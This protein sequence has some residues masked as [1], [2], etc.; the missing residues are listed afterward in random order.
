VFRDVVVAVDGTRAGNEA[1]R[2]AAALVAPG[3]RV[4]LIGVADAYSATINEWAG[5]QLLSADEAA[6]DDSTELMRT[7]LLRGVR[8]SLEALHSQLDPGL[9]VEADVIEGRVRDVLRDVASHADLLALGDHGRS[10]MAGILAAGTVTEL[11]HRS[12]CSV[13]ISRP[14]FDP[15]RFPVRIAVAVDGSEPSLQ[16]LDVGVEIAG[17]RGSRVDSMVAGRGAARAADVARA[18]ADVPVCVLSGSVVGA[19]AEVGDRVDLMLLGAQ[20]HTGTRALG[21][22][23]ERVAHKSSASVLVVRP[24]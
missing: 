6:R 16:A 20:G 23:A 5:E 2:Q 9:H 4:R 21:S 15:A 3:G 24:S 12:D 14:C 1:G 10:R 17:A 19:L 8:G 11:L 18:R 13:L 22:V 7:E